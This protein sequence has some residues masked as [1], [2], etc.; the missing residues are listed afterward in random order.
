MRFAHALP[1]IV[2]VPL[3]ILAAFVV[4]W[5][6]FDDSPLRIINY[7]PFTDRPVESK[8][9]AEAHAI[10]EAKAETIVWAYTE[11]CLD[12]QLRGVVSQS[13]TDGFV[14]VL[15]DRLSVG[16]VG[17]NKK[18]FQIRTPPTPVRKE[19]T[20]QKT[21]AYHLN[22]IRSIRVEFPD[23]SLVVVP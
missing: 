3:Y 13:W 6:F 1:A 19:F 12:R 8:E 5:Q 17:C 15:P 16:M 23:L 4:Y 9:E 21:I 10:A 18:S 22:P 2:L 7:G 14:Y 11:W 20:F